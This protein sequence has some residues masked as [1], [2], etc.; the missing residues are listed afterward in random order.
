[1]TPFGL[2]TSTV[3][4]VRRLDIVLRDTGNYII[5]FVDDLL[6][7]SMD[8][9]E[10]LRH[11]RQLFER[12][13]E[14]G[15]TLKM[16]KSLFFRAEIKFLGHIVATEGIRPQPDNMKWMKEFPRPRNIR[17][18][19]GFLGLVY[20]YTRFTSKHAEETIPLLELLKKGT[21]WKWSQDK[22]DAF[23]K[24][25]NYSVNRWSWRTLKLGD[26]RWEPRS[27]RWIRM[28]RRR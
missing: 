7:V 3:A 4:L 22:E 18:L 11:P 8:P 23:E 10:H 27:R 28:G 5:N 17:Q 6:C 14:H 19:R 24:S 16:K 20:F 26:P 21:P 13:R 2:K 1:M 9:V 15:M 25:R 12:I